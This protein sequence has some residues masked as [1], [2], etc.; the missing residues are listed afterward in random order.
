MSGNP[1]FAPVMINSEVYDE[2]RLAASAQTDTEV[3]AALKEH[4]GKMLRATTGLAEKGIIDFE[5]PDVVAEL[6]DDKV[7]QS[8]RLGKL[9]DLHSR[10]SAIS[11]EVQMRLQLRNEARRALEMEQGFDPAEAGANVIQFPG[12]VKTLANLV[13]MVNAKVK[14]SAGGSHTEAIGQGGLGK[15]EFKDFSA[16]DLQNAMFS[17]S[18]DYTPEMLD[19]GF[20]DAVITPNRVLDLVPQ[21]TGAFGTAYIEETLYAP[22]AAKKVESA[23]G[24]RTSLAE[25]AFKREKRQDAYTARG[26]VVP[27]TEEELI[28]VNDARAYINGRMVRGVMDHLD[29]GI[30]TELTANGAFPEAT[31]VKASKD[32][33]GEIL[34][35]Q[36]AIETEAADQMVSGAIMRPTDYVNLILDAGTDGHYLARIDPTMAAPKRAWGIPIVC[37]PRAVDKQ[38]YL[39]PFSQW[40]EYLYA[41]GLMVDFGYVGD[42]FKELVQTVRA[43]TFAAL[44]IYRPASF[45]R[46]TVRA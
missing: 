30:I 44:R 28:A 13:N 14:K 38:I 1:N 36:A 12:R 7:P 39:G 20:I 10:Q 6:G 2:A 40:I 35:V 42:D 34:K 3:K 5:H 16:I 22:A 24:A 9:I 46:L 31:D 11:D 4:R 25:S 43:Y 29:A 21:R 17:R 18:Q 41:G 32:F 23:Q 15:Q 33:W 27:I 45:R 37:T 19:P 8:E 26:H